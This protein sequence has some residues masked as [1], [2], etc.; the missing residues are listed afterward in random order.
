MANNLRAFAKGEFASLLSKASHCIPVFDIVSAFGTCLL[1]LPEDKI[2]DFGLDEFSSQSD[3][4]VD[5]LLLRYFERYPSI[6][7]VF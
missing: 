3:V 6:P 1:A 2:G 5:R 4:E 7:F